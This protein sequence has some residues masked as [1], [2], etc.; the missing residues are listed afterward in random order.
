MSERIYL[1]HA[2]TTPAAPG[3]VEAMLPY[4][5]G[6]NPSS[7]HAEGRRAR[8]ALD[9]ARDR[10]A[11]LL[12]VARKEIVFSASGSEADTHAIL[13][14]A[15]NGRERGNHIVSTAIEHHAVLHALDA[16]AREGFEITTLPVDR[17]GVVDVERFEAALR[18]TTILAT[19]MYANNEIGTIQPIAQLAAIAHGR[20]ILFHTDAVQAPEWTTVRP[21]ELGVDLLSL[22]AHK[23]YGPKG[24]G[25]LYVREGVDIGVLIHG[26]GQ[27]FG[28][29]AGTENVAGI[30]GFARALEAASAGLSERSARVAFLRDRLEAEVRVRIADVRV[31]GAGAVRLPNITNLSFAGVDSEAMLMALDLAGI[32]AS[33]GSACTSGVLEPSHV[34]RA[35]E[36][37]P[38]WHRGPLRFSLGDGTT[39]QEIERLL[40]VLP[41]IVDDLRGEGMLLQ[42]G[43]REIFDA[44]K[45]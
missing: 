13:G 8:A 39:T 11:A 36:I 9:D 10:V 16:L 4:F 32:A 45:G 35:L 28:R 15:R 30:V 41:G 26:G 43:R 44:Q 5:E 31:N 3:V 14:A 12:G 18:T 17:R 42:P 1:D 2:A 23:F 21:H 7:V 19:V 40:T 22:S 37:D 24:V 27:E 33:A 20:G 25:L 34:I 6:Y 29:R 38:R